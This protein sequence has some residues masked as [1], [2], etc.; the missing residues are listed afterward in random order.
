MIKSNEIVISEALE[1]Y[2]ETIYRFSR[3]QPSVRITDIALHLGL[4]KPSVN[5]AVN[6]LKNSGLV[7]HEPYGDIILTEKG[8]ELGYDLYLR[9]KMIKKFLISVL[10]INSEEAEKETCRIEHGISKNTVEKMAGFME[11]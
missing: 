9:H 1:E 5:R 6:S 2:L 10:K 4:S 3:K 7:F 11:A 8:N